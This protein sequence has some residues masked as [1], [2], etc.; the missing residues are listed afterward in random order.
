MRARRG[1]SLSGSLRWKTTSSRR[2]ATRRR[3]RPGELQADTDEIEQDAKA[4]GGEQVTKDAAT[5]E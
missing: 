3:S 4:A 1:L 2:W 5:Q